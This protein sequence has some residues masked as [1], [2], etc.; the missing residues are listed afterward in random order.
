M[1]NYLIGIGAT[2]CIV[3]ALLVPI[4]AVAFVTSPKPAKLTPL[5]LFVAFLTFD[6][7]LLFL[8]RVVRVIPFWGGEN[9][10]G[11]LLEL[12]WLV[13]LVAFV[14]RF[15]GAFTGLTFTTSEGSWR[16]LLIATPDQKDPDSSPRDAS[17]MS[18]PAIVVRDWTRP[19]TPIL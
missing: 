5:L 11:K 9:W 12:A 7:L 1:Q 13:L 10:Q 17:P 15:T 18:Q 19:A 14:P 8:F 16:V 3:L 2:V 4:F 6:F